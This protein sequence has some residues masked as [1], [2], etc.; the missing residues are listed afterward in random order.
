MRHMRCAGRSDHLR[1]MENGEMRIPCEIGG[2]VGEDTHHAGEGALTK[3]EVAGPNLV[4]SR[5]LLSNTS[6]P[7]L[8]AHWAISAS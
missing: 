2:V 4:K 8:T 7:D 6:A 5:I 1:R 3:R